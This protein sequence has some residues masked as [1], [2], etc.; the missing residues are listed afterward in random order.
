MSS[1]T[2]N[3]ANLAESLEQEIEI[4]LNQALVKCNDCLNQGEFGGALKALDGAIQ[5]APANPDIL[6]HRARLLVFLKEYAL[7]FAD[8]EKAAQIDPSHVLAN[9]GLARCHFDKGSYS[10][11]E[12]FAHRALT[13]DPQNLEAAEV[14]SGVEKITG[15]K[16]AEARQRIQEYFNYARDEFAGVEPPALSEWHLKNSRVLPSREKI[17]ERMPKGGVCAEIGTQT[18]DFARQILTCLKPAKMHIFDIDFTPFDQ[19]AFQS[20]IG[21]GTVELHQG[22]SS[23]ALATLP[24]RS[25]DFI[26]IDGDHAYEGVVKDLAMAAQKIK[27]DGWIVCNDYTIYS[28]VEKMQYGVYR[29]VNEFCWREGF[30]IVF[31]GLHYWSYHDVALRRMSPDAVASAGQAPKPAKARHTGMVQLAG[32]NANLLKPAPA[33]SNPPRVFLAGETF[34]SG[35]NRGIQAPAVSSSPGAN[36]NSPYDLDAGLEL[37]IG[38]HSYI[39]DNKIRNPSGAL[40]K[41]AIGKFCCVASGLSVIGYDHHSE[42]AAMFPFLDDGHRANWP[43]TDGIPYPQSPEFGSNKSRG[44]ISIGNEVWIGSDVKLF[45]GITVGDGAVIGACSLV[46][47]SVDPYTVVAGIPA[48]PIR[49]RFSDQEIKLLQKIQWWDLPEAL[50]NRHMGLLCSSNI[51][52]LEHALETDPE[53]QNFK[54][55]ISARTASHKVRHLAQPVNPAPPMDIIETIGQGDEMFTGD[56]EHYFGVG[57]SALHG[58]ETALSAA[59]Q[60]RTKIL[61]ILDLPCGHGRVMRH[62]KAAFPHAQITACDLNRGAVDF[63]AQTFGALPVYSKVDVDQIAL[64]GNYDLIWSGSLLTHLRPGACAEFIRLWNSLINPGGLIVFTLHGR[65][66]ERSLATRRYTYG[67]KEHDVVALLK[68][69]YETGFGYADYPGQSGYGISV[70]SPSYVLSKLV[71]LPDLKLISYQEKGWDNHQDIVCLQKQPGNELLG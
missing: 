29:A 59:R 40:T 17:L 42:W 3:I 12:A 50:I 33:S 26:Y 53:F 28:P 52:E 41:I 54:K 15:A 32:K 14:L 6:N 55:G 58:I 35:T 60:P 22:D 13:A 61:N 64:P 31:L 10:E 62:L 44:D 47:K 37:E 70:S 68:E 30:E 49:K 69:Y 63:C 51:V 20:S 38:A 2:S 48:R 56:R 21:N 34:S 66:V 7:A 23:A 5:L 45:K 43:G 57:K 16:S 65:W 4:L 71:S 18:G 24:D 1:L 25:F 11:A 39:H 9:A 67:L 27:A 8:F 46:N 36:S 19:A